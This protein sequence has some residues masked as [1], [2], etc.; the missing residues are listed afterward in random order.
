MSF[1]VLSTFEASI[2]EPRGGPPLSGKAASADGVRTYNPLPY[3]SH[4]IAILIHELEY[5]KPAIPQH[6]YFGN[7]IPNIYKRRHASKHPHVAKH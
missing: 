5:C 1:P 4:T 3:V 7:T 2:F 6:S